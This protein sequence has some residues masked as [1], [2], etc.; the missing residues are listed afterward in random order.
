MKISREG[1]ESQVLELFD[2][3]LHEDDVVIGVLRYG[4]HIPHIYQNACL[5]RGLT[6]KPVRLLLSHMLSFF[7]V[8]FYQKNN[9]VILDD[10]VYEGV[11]MAN[12]LERVQR[13]YNI[14]RERIRTATLIRH[15]ESQFEPDYPSEILR[16]AQYIAWKEE[17]ASLVRNDIRPTERDHPLYYFEIEKLEL[18]F[19][20]SLLEDYGYIHPVG[21][22][23]D[24][25]IFRL[26]LTIDSSVV[27]NLLP[28]PGID[29]ENIFK[30][31]IYWNKHPN[32][33]RL[34]MAP[35]GFPTINIDSFIH[36]KASQTLAELLGLE[37]TFFEEIYR[38]HPEQLRGQMLF[39]FASRSIAALLIQHLL[40][41]ITPRLKRHG[42]SISCIDPEVVDGDVHYIFPKEY[43][44][45]YACVFAR[46]K[47]II[48]MKPDLGSLPFVEE[49]KKPERNRRKASED[50]LLPD[51]YRTLA[52]ITQKV[53]P[54][55]WNGKRWVPNRELNTGVSHQQL[56]CEFK[57][58]LF[59][60]AALDELLDS[61]LMRAKDA[62][63]DMSGNVFTRIFLSGGEYNAVQVSR[64]ADTWR[65]THLSID[66]KA[67]EEEALELW[68][69]Y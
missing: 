13:N 35:M 34:T 67:I 38:S 59:V 57:D 7:P 54:A 15:E 6:P 22:N 23:W 56:V 17:L 25:P 43:I 39:Y 8:E 30:I 14:A 9:F 69:A 21:N 1:L 68:G 62:A 60:S 61:G 64:I 48:S 10:T 20:L 32:G 12:W 45:F 53:D 63:V 31:R 16:D 52:F 3:Y 65:S 24:T 50:P 40:I 47:E 41:Q 18:G 44:S 28:L 46:L 19:L 11:E 58:S 49:W 66:P 4:A 2:T 5:K 37:S 27:K 29:L 36:S 55:I 42:C 33:F 26:S 51:I